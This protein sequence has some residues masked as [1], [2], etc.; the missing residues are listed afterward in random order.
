M[1]NKMKF[2]WGGDLKLNTVHVEDVC[3]A[4]W[5]LTDHGEV[6]KIYNLVDKNDTDQKKLNELLEGL[7]QIK[8][9]FVNAVYCKFA[10][11]NIKAATEAVNDKHLR[12]WSSLCGSHKIE[13]TPLSPF[14]APELLYDHSLCVDGSALES[15]GFALT[16]P[17]ITV[18]LLQRVVDYWTSQGVF[19]AVTDAEKA[20][21]VG[22]DEDDDEE[23]PSGDEE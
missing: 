8:T 19:P 18:E 2:L 17:K 10:K 11:L 13:T 15:T 5:H 21:P 16:H 1:G 14:L 22:A 6:K 3:A 9:G 23:V 12:P 7:F 20:E 4:L